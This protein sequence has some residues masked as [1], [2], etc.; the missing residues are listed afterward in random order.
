[1]AHIAR[2]L[3]AG[4]VLRSLLIGWATGA[5]SSLGPGAATLTGDGRRVVRIGA[6]AGIVGELVGD[7]LPTAPSRLD[8]G[9]ALLRAAAGAFGASTLARRASASPVVPALVAAAAGFASAHAGASWRR[10]AVGRMPDWQAALIEDAVAIGAA[11]A[12]C[13]PRRRDL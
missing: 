2:G 8:H 7:K 10:W 6:A 5:R 12:A 1:M 11:A 4:L 13:L 3:G 9:G